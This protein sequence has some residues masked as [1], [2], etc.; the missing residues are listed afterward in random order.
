MKYV[1]QS[2]KSA[3]QFAAC[4]RIFPA[5]VAKITRFSTTLMYMMQQLRR[6][7]YEHDATIMQ[8]RM[9]MMQELPSL[10]N[11]DR[12]ESRKWIVPR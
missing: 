8:G 12:V 4:D 9:C 11:A 7:P 6:A 3:N 10:F 5:T 1:L 2:G